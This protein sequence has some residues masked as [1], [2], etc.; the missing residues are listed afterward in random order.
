MDAKRFGEAVRGH[1]PPE[2]SDRVCYS[3]NL[4]SFEVGVVLDPVTAVV[5]PVV[6]PDYSTGSI[7]SRNNF[8]YV[9][10]ERG[11]VHHHGDLEL[12]SAAISIC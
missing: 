2:S 5:R 9:M 12:L 7:G 11:S 8:L 3:P 10:H 4:W 1:Y 6:V